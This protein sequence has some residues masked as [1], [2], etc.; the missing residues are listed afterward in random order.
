MNPSILDRLVSIL[1]Y[2][3]FGIFSIV[4][5]IF[6]NVVGKPISQFLNFNLYQAIFLS[7]ALAVLSLIYSIGINLLSVVP[8]IGSIAKGFDL[9]FNQTPIYYTFTMSG[10]LVS[11]LILYLSILSLLGKRPYLP[12]VSDIIKANFG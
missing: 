8:F 2:F 1:S 9:F 4:W 10:F 3:T 5:I 11:L 6:A 12:I 7:V